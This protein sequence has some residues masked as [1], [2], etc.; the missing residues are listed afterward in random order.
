MTNSQWFALQVKYRHEKHV[1]QALRG[2]GFDEYLPL[3]RSEH[4]SGRRIVPVDLPL[5][6]TYVFCSFDPQ[7]K[8]LVLRT[9]GVF[10]VVSSAGRSLPVDLDELTAVRTMAESGLRIEP[11]THLELGDRVTVEH[12]PLRGTTGILQRI[13][14]QDRLV[15]SIGLLRS[16]VAVEIDRHIVRRS[17]AREPTSA[18]RS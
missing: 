3:Y 13:K 10:G 4:R 12:G 18:A 1:S 7:Q 17:P 9:P 6:P 15:V 5:F 11:C 2:K 14:N 16:S 8:L